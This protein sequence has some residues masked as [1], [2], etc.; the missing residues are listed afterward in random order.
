MFDFFNK[1]DKYGELQ[2]L[3]ESLIRANRLLQRAMAI[4]G[5]NSDVAQYWSDQADRLEAEIKKYE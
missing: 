5:V 4:K 3:K 2:V 1:Q